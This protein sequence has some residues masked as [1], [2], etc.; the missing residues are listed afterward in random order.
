MFNYASSCRPIGSKRITEPHATIGNGAS[1]INTHLSTICDVDGR[2]A[3]VHGIPLIGPKYAAREILGYALAPLVGA[4]V[5]DWAIFTATPNNP[6]DDGRIRF[7]NGHV[8]ASF[9]VPDAI[10]VASGTDYHAKKWKLISSDLASI[11]VFHNWIMTEF[12]SGLHVRTATEGLFSTYSTLHM[13]HRTWPN[14]KPS[15]HREINCSLY[16][17][18]GY[19]VL[20]EIESTFKKLNDI[21]EQSIIDVV[22][23]IPDGVDM[24]TVDERTTMKRWLIDRARFLAVHGM[25]VFR[26]SPIY[27]PLRL[28]DK[29]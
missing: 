15:N 25:D 7:Y 9:L 11:F 16:S 24:F 20:S 12:Q 19:M 28:W 27:P 4:R 5:P 21:P 17:C 23:A 10:T 1:G 29:R 2:T 13:V 14:D 3:L 26:N 6:I 8:L 18:A 22:N